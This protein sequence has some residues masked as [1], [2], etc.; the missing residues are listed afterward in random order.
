MSDLVNCLD[1]LE[2]VD[3]IDVGEV[4]EWLGDSGLDKFKGAE[5]PS[6]EGFGVLQKKKK[7]NYICPKVKQEA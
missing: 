6:D 7:D 5:Y 2:E 4:V 1:D 3:W